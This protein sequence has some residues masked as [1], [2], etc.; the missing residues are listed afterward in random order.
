MK[1][2][3]EPIITENFIDLE[4][5]L[6]AK[7]VKAPKWVVRFLNRLLH[8]K[9]LNAGIYR[10]REKKGPAFAQAVLDDLQVDVRLEHAERIPS[11]GNPIMVANH[12]L[13]G[14]DGMALIAAVGACRSDIRFPV[15]DFLMYLPGLRPV[16]V[17]IDKVHG[18]RHTAA[19]L[20]EA[21]AGDNVLLYFPAGLCSRRIKGKITDLEWKPTMVKKAVQH[22]RDIIPVYIEAR[23]R[24]RFYTIANWRKRL[25]IKFNF[26]IALLP[27]EMFAQRGKTMRI[28]V[29]VPVPW[30]TLADDT[31]AVEW[32]RRLHDHVYR[33]SDNPDSPFQ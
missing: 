23:N 18:N 5:V 22:H 32:A 7:G 17:P 6:A 16:F 11:E 26:E 10:N 9:E 15:N 2:E 13:G 24:R 30:Q 27:G 14:P 1:N 25:G 3:E 33:L 8:V 19:G 12:P 29:G 28:V 31:P 20:N 21:F 4:K